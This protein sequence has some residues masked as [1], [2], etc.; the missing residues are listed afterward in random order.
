MILSHLYCRAD[1]VGIPGAE[2]NTLIDD[3]IFSLAIST[4]SHNASL[5]QPIEIQ[6]P[7]I[8]TAAATTTM[9][10]SSQNMMSTNMS[11]FCVFWDP[12]SQ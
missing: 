5:K 11:A 12:E 1:G 8:F 6:L 3:V 4:V 9:L 2:E 7:I 10:D